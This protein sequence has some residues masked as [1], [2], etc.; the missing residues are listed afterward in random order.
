MNDLESKMKPQRIVT[1][2]AVLLGTLAAITINA[3][4][5]FNDYI[6]ANTFMIGNYFPPALALLLAALLLGNAALHRFTAN[7]ALTREEL[8]IIVMMILVSCSIPTTGLFRTFLPSLT[9][10]FYFGAENPQFWNSFLQANLP[11][12]LFPVQDYADARGSDVIRNF[13]GKILAGESVPYEA[14]VRPLAMWGIFLAALLGSFICIAWITRV[15][16]SENERL[17]FPL[18]Q[19]QAMLIEP[20]TRGQAFNQLFRH[21]GF[22]IVIVAVVLFHSA[23]ALS[24]Y[25][26]RVPSIPTMPEV[27]NFRSV[28]SDEPW[29]HLPNALVQSP[30]FFSVVGIA[31][32][33][34]TRVV[35]SMWLI[36]VVSQ[37]TIGWGNATNSLTVSAEALQSQHVGACIA[38]TAGMLFVGRAFYT[39]VLLGSLGSRREVDASCVWAMRILIAC[40]VLMFAWNLYIGIGWLM[41]SLIV[42]LTMMAHLTTARIVAETGLPMV[43]TQADLRDVASTMPAGLFSTRD[44]VHGGIIS[45]SS[46]PSARESAMVFAQH[47]VQ[48]NAQ[49]GALDKRPRT[50]AALI[51]WT[52]AISFVT[53]SV[54]SLWCYYNYDAPITP[55]KNFTMVNQDIALGHG[56]ERVMNLTNDHADGS[57]RDRPYSVLGHMAIGGGI[58]VALQ[59]LTLTVNSWPLLPVGYLMAGTVYMNSLWFSLLIGWLLKSVLVGVGGS[60]VLRVA[61]PL[62]VGLII[63][64]IFAAAIWMV[65]NLIL[66]L[67]GYNYFPVQI[68]LT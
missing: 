34:R 20:P 8:G 65:V 50:I 26:D 49:T 68:L 32:F 40:V 56:R 19:L 31:F 48:L 54:S 53:A 24:K 30:F 51:V 33:M 42:G 14:W 25:D 55:L 46:T 35:L 43:R 1:V 44:V 4:A 6:V 52:L 5:P 67:N 36:Y 38:Y 7:Q 37:L 29:R 47:G 12:W 57:F 13:Y 64:E 17:P 3:I 45:M 23:N 41:A 2:R 61:Q 9:A 58:V 60:R 66:A 59:T 27:F 62:F 28:F 63:G 21:P 22:W 10:P 16:W 39:R 18:V 15:Q 11:T